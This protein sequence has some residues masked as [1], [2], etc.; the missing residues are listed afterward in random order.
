MAVSKKS[1]GYLLL[2][3][4]IIIAAVVIYLMQHRSSSTPKSSSTSEAKPQSAPIPPSQRSNDRPEAKKPATDTQAASPAESASADPKVTE[5]I[6][7]SL[8]QFRNNTDPNKAREILRQLREGIRQARDDEAAAAIIA[9]LKTGEDAA[10]G[11]TFIVGPDGMMDTVPTLR[12][13]LLDLL[14]SLDPT[15]ALNVARELMDKRT[16]PDEYAISLRNL[17]WND[18]DGDLRDELTTRFFDLLKTPWLEQPTAGLLESFDVPVEIGGIPMFNE[19][20]SLT[21]RSPQQKAVNQAAF[22]SLDRMVQR[23]PSL[24]N[25]ALAD[26]AWMASA[27]QQRASLLSRLDITQPDQRATFLRYISS[28][29]HGEGELDYY[30]RIFPNANFLYGNRLV[31]T[32]S[33][34]PSISDVAA[35]DAKVVD[36][37]GKLGPS[38]TGEAAA[39]IEKIRQRLIQLK[40]K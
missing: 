1:R 4:L 21:T 34:A 31:T 7:S 8:E 12:L 3:I 14:P 24:L 37:L 22:I 32:D 29:P 2:G 20:I 36:E 33:P 10:T 13:A 27:P 40:A 5:L 17:A 30:A 26:P 19:L 39:T 16:S 35:S 28:V 11:L 23:D 18:L 38:L 25:A 6:R 9:F 15:A